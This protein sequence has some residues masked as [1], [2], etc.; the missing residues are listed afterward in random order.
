MLTVNDIFILAAALVGDHENDDQD[1]KNFAVP[2]LNIL[3]QECLNVENDLRERDKMELLPAAPVITSTEDEVPY[4]DDLC[5]VALPYG[6]AW[7]Y[8]QEAGNLSL[9]AQYRNMYI[10]AVDSKRC[11]FMRRF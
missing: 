3:L 6:L 1:E 2:Y 10:E 9:A 4:H 8:Q 11:F 5:R 7:Q